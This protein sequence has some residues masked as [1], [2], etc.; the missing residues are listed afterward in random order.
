MLTQPSFERFDFRNDLKNE[1]MAKKLYTNINILQKHHIGCEY[2]RYSD[3]RKYRSWT[4]F[5]T[6]VSSTIS[7]AK[8][9]VSHLNG[10]KLTFRENTLSL[11]SSGRNKFIYRSICV[12]VI[13][14]SCRIQR[15]EGKRTPTARWWTVKGKKRGGRAKGWWEWRVG[16]TSCSCRPVYVGR[17]DGHL[18]EPEPQLGTSDS[19]SGERGGTKCLSRSHDEIPDTPQPLCPSNP[20]NDVHTATRHPRFPRRRDCLRGVVVVVLMMVVVFVVCALAGKERNARVLLSRPRKELP[21][22]ARTSRL[23][24][25]M[26]R[27]TGEPLVNNVAFNVIYDIAYMCD[28]QNKRTNYHVGQ[29]LKYKPQY[30]NAN[31]HINRL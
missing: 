15:G 4:I 11:L 2:D 8:R 16:L 12:D 5:F 10:T 28:L 31:C 7:F 18:W 26:K 13:L 6:S 3:D 30:V 29:D 20:P 19:K 23:S 17:G 24:L 1:N 27:N 14:R 21:W 9:D 22:H 25:L